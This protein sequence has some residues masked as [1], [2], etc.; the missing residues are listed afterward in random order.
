MD[1][2]PREP[3]SYG[4]G[5]RR[6]R[7]TGQFRPMSGEHD[8]SPYVFQPFVARRFGIRSGKRQS[9]RAI[10]PALS[11]CKTALEVVAPAYSLEYV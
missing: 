5:D 10:D 3:K 11:Y 2:D 7:V 9:I 4:F 6:I 8:E 1:Q